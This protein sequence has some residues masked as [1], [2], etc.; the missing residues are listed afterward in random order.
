MYICLYNEY[1]TI[2]K[3]EQC[4]IEFYAKPSW[5]KN[6]FGKYCS[7]KCSHESNKKG[8]IVQC[9]ICKSDVY[10][11]RKA[12]IGSK[13]KKYF[14]SKSCQTT[15]RNSMVFI[16]KNHANWKNGKS[17]YRNVLIK[18]KEKKAC[19]LCS[20]NDIR[21][22]AVHHVDKNNLNNDIDNLVWLCHNCH[23]LVH[24]YV[25]EKE[26]LNIMISNKN[27]KK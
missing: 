15:W 27:L 17:T 14:C 10:K 20:K 11:S 26:G 13:S 9:F 12:L 1:M 16:G 8:K 6:G 19:N 7:R 24:H 25:K 3:C 18:S 5:L 21:L 2:V 22:L 23:F 4:N